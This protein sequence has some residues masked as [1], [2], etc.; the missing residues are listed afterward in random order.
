M[1]RIKTMA[2]HYAAKDF[3]KAV[4]AAMVAEEVTRQE[5]GQELNIAQGTLRRRLDQHPEELTVDNLRVLMKTIRLPVEAV[6]CLIT[7]KAWT[8]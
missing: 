6:M 1:P 3:K 4:S 5:L 2:D 7:E 8:E